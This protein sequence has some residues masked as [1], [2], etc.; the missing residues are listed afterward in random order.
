MTWKIR[1]RKVLDG[2]VC[3]PSP[4]RINQNE[5]ASEFN[6]FLDNDN[7]K[8]H[9]LDCNYVKRD[10]FN[11]VLINHKFAQY[12]YIFSHQ[13]SG[14]MNA[15]DFLGAESGDTKWNSIGHT[16]P[17]IE[18]AEKTFG[19]MVTSA[20]PRIS[21]VDTG[22]VATAHSLGFDAPDGYPLLRHREEQG[23]NEALIPKAGAPYGFDQTTKLPF[24]KFTTE[25]D[26]LL[27]AELSGTLTWLNYLGSLHDDDDYYRSIWYHWMG[28]SATGWDGSDLKKAYGRG[29]PY[30]FRS[31]TGTR[32]NT[33]VHILCTSFRIVLDGR[34]VA[35]T[36][37]LGPEMIHQ[38]IYLCG[39]EPIPAGDHVLQVEARTV[40]YN[41]VRSWVGSSSSYDHYHDEID[42][43]REYVRIDSCLRFPNL[44]AQIRS[45]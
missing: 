15:G 17:R 35:S 31:P 4:W 3:E 2:E 41:P 36:G 16:K 23:S 24:Y 29:N 10:T 19:T 5:I 44:I 34:E 8:N 6:G 27:I 33:R 28:D 9:G 14:W 12:S 18:I 13:Q 20:F 42:D 39:A 30:E 40:W 43:K 22:Q 38:P 45:R 37:L 32:R 1:Q 7:L 21:K 11:Q 26:S 25:T